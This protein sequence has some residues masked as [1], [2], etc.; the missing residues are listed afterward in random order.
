MPTIKIVP[1]PGVS[2][3]GPQGPQGPVGPAGSNGTKGAGFEPVT[4]ELNGPVGFFRNPNGAISEAWNFATNVRVSSFSNRD[5]YIEGYILSINHEGGTVRVDVLRDFTGD[6]YINDWVMELTGERGADGDGFNFRGAWVTDTLYLKNDVVTQNG[7]SY[8]ANYDYQDT[9]GPYLD[10]DLWATLALKG[11]DGSGGGG[12]TAD[13]IFTSNEGQSVI[14]LPGDKGMKIEAGVDS[15]LYLTAGD[16]LY[17]QTLGQG[18][19]IHLNAADD[20]RFTTNNEDSAFSS[21]PTWRMNSEGRFELPGNGYISNPYAE[22]VT[23]QTYTV[24]FSDNYLNNQSGLSQA[25]AV[26]L[27]VISDSSWFVNNFNITSPVTITFADSTTTTTVAIYDA[28]SQGTPA[29]IFQWDD[30]ERNKTFAETFPL[31]ISA[32][33]NNISYGASTIELDP[34]WYGNDQKIVIEATNPNHIHVRPGGNIDESTAHLYLGGERNHV[35]I[36]DSYKSVVVSTAQT[37]ENIYVNASEVSNADLLVPDTADIIVGD[38]ILI[39]LSTYPVT[40]FSPDPLN[41]GFSIVRATDA[42]FVSGDSY[43]FVRDQP[44]ENT[45][46]FLSNGTLSGPAMGGLKVLGILNSGPYDLEVYA[47]DADINLQANSGA[48]NIAASEI[49]INSNSVPSSLNINTY[50]GAVINSARTASYAPGDKVVATLGDLESGPKTWT[51]PNNQPYSI[52]QAHGGVEVTTTG[53][54]TYTFLNVICTGSAGPTMG[55]FYFEDGEQL[56]AIM[57]ATDPSTFTRKFYIEGSNGIRSNVVNVISSGQNLFNL[58]FDYPLT[59]VQESTYNIVWEYGGQPEIWWDADNLNIMPEG[60]EWKF[61][62]AKIDYHAYST[63]SGTIIGTIYIAH[64]SGDSNTTHVEVT[65]GN[66]D[67]SSIILW[68]RDNTQYVSERKLYAYRN[69]GEQS[70]TRIQWTAQVYYGTEYWD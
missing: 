47:N 60:Q 4:L 23:T 54:E 46:Q 1:M 53:S 44:Y 31:T 69:D 13:F 26:Y 3:P 49:N 10:G 7:S 34:E 24:S 38:K 33:Y 39:G 2:V 70:T 36:S 15:D 5:K 43:T 29:V 6:D 56:D 51:S 55:Q 48:V 58:Y 37:T 9:S 14:S 41:G 45:W 42:T 21:V 50:S 8:I 22:T 61:R 64:D 62:G 17:I 20:I 66:N 52:H 57:T 67:T 27:P 19:D 25:Y 30:Q 32:Q 18:D 63:D 59:L 35:S 28:T 40:Y 68:K 65:S 12:D 16:D 11:Q